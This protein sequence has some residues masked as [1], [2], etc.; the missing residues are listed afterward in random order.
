VFLN[1]KVELTK[2]NHLI[3]NMGALNVKLTE[4]DIQRLNELGDRVSGL[5][6]KVKRCA[7]RYLINQFKPNHLVC[8]LYTFI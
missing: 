2:T 3:D 4:E 1:V 7:Y 5:R 6:M 8:N